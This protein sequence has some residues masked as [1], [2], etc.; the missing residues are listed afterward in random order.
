MIKIK[1]GDMD[2]DGKITLKDAV[3]ILKKALGIQD[4]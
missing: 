1:F 4:N 2:S 3:L